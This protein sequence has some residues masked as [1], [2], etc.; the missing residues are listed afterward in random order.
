MASLNAHLLCL[1]I[2]K[3]SLN[4]LSA[5]QSTMQL[6]LDHL[7]LVALTVPLLYLIP[8][9]LT[10]AQIVIVILYS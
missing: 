5:N 6:I 7:M 8:W 2:M 10:A 3:Q 4:T 9:K 1:L